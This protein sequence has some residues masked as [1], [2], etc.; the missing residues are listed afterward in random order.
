[1]DTPARSAREL[2]TCGPNTKLIHKT[3]STRQIR[4]DPC[5]EE[6]HWKPSVVCTSE[7]MQN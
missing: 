4:S 2:A 1:M 3:N 7:L 6:V 5:L